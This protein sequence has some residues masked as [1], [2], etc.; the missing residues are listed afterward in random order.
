MTENESEN[1]ELRKIKDRKR[2]SDKKY[3]ENKKRKET[4]C[5]T[6]NESETK[7]KINNIECIPKE[8]IK[9]LQEDSSDWSEWWW[10]TTI[11][12]FKMLGQTIIQSFTTIAVPALIMWMMPRQNIQQQITSSSQLPLRQ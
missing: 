3:Y 2:I 11:G 1:A 7:I 6:K 12:T 9:K 5:E 4:E 8:E 10:E